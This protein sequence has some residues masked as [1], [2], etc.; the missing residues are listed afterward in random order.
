M[1]KN[2]FFVAILILASC[3]KQEG[4]PAR[5]NNPKLEEGEPPVMKK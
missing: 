1:K 5:S 3:G 2:L 4:A